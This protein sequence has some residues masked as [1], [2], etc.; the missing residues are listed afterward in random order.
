M[1]WLKRNKQVYVTSGSLSLDRINPFF[2][3]DSG[4]RTDVI[5]GRK[6]QIDFRGQSVKTVT[7]YPMYNVSVSTLVLDAL[8]ICVQAYC[9]KQ[10]YNYLISQKNYLSYLGPVFQSPKK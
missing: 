9:C 4:R 10:K 7:S 5:P 8:L 6:T 3:N 2:L 1:S